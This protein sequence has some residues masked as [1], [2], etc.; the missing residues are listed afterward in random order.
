MLNVGD[1]GDVVAVAVAVAVAAGDRLA[2]AGDGRPAHRQNRWESHASFSSSN[3]AADM[4]KRIVGLLCQ[5]LR[6]VIKAVFIK[7]ALIIL[8][9]CH[10]W[11]CTSWGDTSANHAV[12]IAYLFLLNF[13]RG[14]TKI[15]VERTKHICACIIYWVKNVS[16]LSHLSCAP[17]LDQTLAGW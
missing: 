1:V 8:R 2:A 15:R 13:M 7:A 6:D 3:K 4:I 11:V 10:R 14:R 16:Y 5:L 12:D 17:P 9:L